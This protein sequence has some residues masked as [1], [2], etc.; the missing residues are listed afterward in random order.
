[1]HG[2]KGKLYLALKESKL[3]YYKTYEVSRCSL[4]VLI[5]VLHYF[6]DWLKLK[7]QLEKLV[8]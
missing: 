2:V 8:G 1:M 7:F 3:C 6:M 4:L 5:I